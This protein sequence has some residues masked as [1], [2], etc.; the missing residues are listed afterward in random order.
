VSANAHGSPRSS[1]L[2][3][4]SLAGAVLPILATV[5]ILAYN[6]GIW[7]AL[8]TAALQVG[9]ALLGKTFQDA[10]AAVV[11]GFLSASI[12]FLLG[13]A[14]IYLVCALVCS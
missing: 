5:G 12:L 2:V 1:E 3:A 10:R 13:L 11:W 7:A 14:S 9:V 6:L 4:A 8:L